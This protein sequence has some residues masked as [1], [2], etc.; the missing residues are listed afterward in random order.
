TESSFVARNIDFRQRSVDPAGEAQESACRSPGHAESRKA[1]KLIPAGEG[2]H[3]AQPAGQ[4]PTMLHIVNQAMV[5]GTLDVE[6]ELPKSLL[7]AC[8]QLRS[9]PQVAGQND[10]WAE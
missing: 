5:N 7:R 4:P 10:R 8:W 2:A 3:H 6:I 1:M 9:I